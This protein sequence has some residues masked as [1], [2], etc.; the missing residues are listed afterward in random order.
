MVQREQ[1][2][3][4]PDSNQTPQQKEEQEKNIKRQNVASGG[5]DQLNTLGHLWHRY[6]DGDVDSKDDMIRVDGLLKFASD[7]EISPQD[8]AMLIIFWKLGSTEQYALS[9]SQFINGFHSLGCKSL[10]D[11]KR[12]LPEWERE[13]L[14]FNVGK[15]RELY[16]FA[17][18][19][20][21]DPTQKS[22]QLDFAV[23]TARLILA[24]RYPDVEH[25]CNFLEHQYGKAITLDTWVRMWDFVMEIGSNIDLYD[26]DDA[27][28]VAL[29]DYV[30]YLNGLKS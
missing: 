24:N 17:Y 27:W 11:I 30:V 15:H 20:N 19:Y 7:L 25:W 22:M 26:P 10:A 12:Y 29:D 8:I 16:L 9:H 3:Q 18:Q 28:P 6:R 4:S 14:E 23:P 1:R 13:T 2:S 21:K 5:D